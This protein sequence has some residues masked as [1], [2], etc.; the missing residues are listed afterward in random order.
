MT[1]AIW[2]GPCPALIEI[3]NGTHLSQTYS[4]FVAHVVPLRPGK[5][6]GLSACF[7]MRR[8]GECCGPMHLYQ[9]FMAVADTSCLTWTQV[10]KGSPAAQFLGALLQPEPHRRPKL[11]QVRP[12]TFC[13]S[14]CRGVV[15]GCGSAD[16]ASGT[17]SIS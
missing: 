2:Q 11:D 12:T 7:R 14:L 1:M 15:M 9:A 17:S 10:E 13:L 8:S 6:I 3:S 16:H 5:R 4:M